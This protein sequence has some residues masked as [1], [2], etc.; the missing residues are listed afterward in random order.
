MLYENVELH[1]VD[2]IGN[3][4]DRDAVRIQRIP[5]E[6]RQKVNPGAQERCLWPFSSEIRLAFEG[7]EASVTLSSDT[8]Q[9]CVV[10]QGPF[11]SE[12]LLIRE[13]PQTVALRRGERVELMHEK[14]NKDLP[15]S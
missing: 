2:G 4:D 3:A 9:D 13:E 5:E 11:R 12:T 10:Y 15:F 1:N 14:D 7:D 6:L 8:S